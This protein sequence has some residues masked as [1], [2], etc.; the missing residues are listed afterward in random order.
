MSNTRKMWMVAAR[1]NRLSDGLRALICAVLLAGLPAAAASATT[2]TTLAVTAGGNPVT[3]LASGTAVTLTATVLAGSAPVTPGRVNFC[4]S[5]ATYCEDIHLLGS[6]QLT[7]AGTAT[8]TF[9]PAI[10]GHSYK[11]VFVGTTSYA[12]SASGPSALTVTGTDLTATAITSSGSAG[13]YTLTGI[14]TAFG[15]L[16]P[17]GQMFFENQTNANAIAA[18]ATLDGTT[19]ANSFAPIQSYGTGINPYGVAVA[20]F[21]DDGILDLAVVNN[22][23]NNVSVLLGHGDGT[24]ASAVNYSV[25]NSPYAVAVGDFN[26]DGI[27]DLVVANY[28]DNTV[29]I[30]LG[31][32]DG[33]FAVQPA[34]AAG[35]L[36]SS[37]AVGDF[38]NDGILDLAV[39]DY[40]GGP[41]SVSI[42]LGNGNGTFQPAVSYPVGNSPYGIAVA[43]FNDDGALDVVTANYGS[44][45]VSVLLGNGDGTFQPQTTYSVATGGSNA[46]GVAV[47]DFNGDG[48]PDI[49]VASSGNVSVLLNNGNGTFNTAVGYSAGNTAYAIAVGDFN[50]DGKADLAVAN[51]N[52]L[53]LSILL[54]N[55]DGTFGSPSN[56]A[57]GGIPQA[58]AVGDFNGDGRPDLVAAVTG[59]ANYAGVLLGAQTETATATGVSI[60]GSGTQSVFASYSSDTNYDTSF[61]ST[62]ALTGSGISTTVVVAATPNPLTWGQ[63]PSVVATLTPSNATGITAADFTAFLDGTTP[64][65]VTAKGG[66]QFLITSAVLS[67]LSIGP[68]TIQVN[69]EGTANY[70][71]SSGD[72]SLQVNQIIPTISWS[73]ALG[74]IYGATLNGILDASALNGTFPVPGSFTYTATPSGGSPSPV[75]SATILFVGSYTLTATFTPTD[76][77][78]DTSG[79]ANVSLTVNKASATVSLVSSLN[80]VLLTNPVTFTATVSSPTS[81]PSGTVSLYDGTTLLG[82][83]LTLAQGVATYTTSSLALGTHLITVN[84]SGDSNFTSVT[85]SALAQTVEDFTLT[86]STPPAGTPAQPVYPGSTAT[87][88]I[89]VGPTSGLNFPS[90]VTFAISGLPAGATA[91]F[92]PKSLPAGSAGTTVNLAI[93]LANQILARNPAHPL[94]RLALAMAGGMLLLPFGRKLRRS[95]TRKGRFACLLLLMLAVTCSTL[96]LTACGGGYF[97]QQVRNYTLTITATSGA[98]S[99]STTTILTVQ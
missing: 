17:T 95:T 29:T 92:T 11:A 31:N 93:Q 70:L 38:N 57:A 81:T 20:D 56:T 59:S 9:I 33:T 12:S 97:G 18:T 55:G 77:T 85:S 62:V 80:P 79:S 67:T 36:P 23:S 5:T 78:H 71:P 64:L 15:V 3:T 82:L 24:F 83:P 32:G 25:G 8:L 2:T 63:T 47:G 76:T 1:V 49:A 46:Y 91:S 26:S 28:G 34:I 60:A 51:V 52:S 21:K 87:Y 90:P 27:P 54:G 39:A 75:T 99:H 66:N 14:L 53:N 16:T 44:D 4:D 89:Q 43:D 68:H 65:T 40:S 61:S 22:G 35:S 30:L 13:N 72:A 58:L 48:S 6:A 86:F 88:V 42:L 10:G 98:L 19:L 50:V 84:Y 96:G 7:G 37:V 73:P 45:N 41:G 69:F 74:I 94:G